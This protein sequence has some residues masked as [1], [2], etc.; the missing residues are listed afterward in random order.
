[1][2]RYDS[3]RAAW[4]GA[5]PRPLP[6]PSVVLVLTF[7]SCLL[8]SAVFT[9]LGAAEP[10]CL[11]LLTLVVAVASWHSTP[12]ASLCVAA[13]AMLFVVGFVEEQAGNLVWHGD[14]DLLRLSLFVGLA[15]L[16]SSARAFARTLR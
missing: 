1:M 9:E 2:P 11:A 5:Q 16:A 13:L 8:L 4:E 3:D 7:L 12:V 10:A 15:L 14:A 6:S